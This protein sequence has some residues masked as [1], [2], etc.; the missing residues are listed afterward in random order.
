MSYRHV[1]RRIVG[2][3]LGVGMIA[4]LGYS[5][6][7]AQDTIRAASGEMEADHDL[8]MLSDLVMTTYARDHRLC[9]ASLRTGGDPIAYAR[10]DPPPEDEAAEKRANVG[11]SCLGLD[12]SRLYSGKNMYTYEVEGDRFVLHAFRACL[13]DPDGLLPRYERRGEVQSGRVV[14]DRHLYRVAPGG[15]VFP[16]HPCSPS[17]ST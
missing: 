16:G 10:N 3:V 17:P 12:A 7:A 11:F 6:S 1:V 2:S 15:K 4:V 13:F 14:L 8:S 5:V 9:G